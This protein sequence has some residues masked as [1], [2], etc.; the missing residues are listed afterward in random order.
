[1][2][3]YR[4]TCRE[5]ALTIAARNSAASRMASR[6]FPTAVGPTTT[7][8][9]GHDSSS[10]STCRYYLSMCLISPKIGPDCDKLLGERCRPDARWARLVQPPGGFLTIWRFI[11]RMSILAKFAADPNRKVLNRFSTVVDEINALE[12]EFEAMSDDELRA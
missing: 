10:T 12:P 3:M 5:S 1:M 4:Y 6:L 7:M 9:R 2:S 11:A 8:V